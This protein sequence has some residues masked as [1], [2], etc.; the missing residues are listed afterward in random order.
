[1]KDKSFIFPF[2]RTEN[3]NNLKIQEYMY[4]KKKKGKIRNCSAPFV[5]AA[6]IDIKLINL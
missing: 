4:Y 6:S 2:Y 3:T 5:I 1:M